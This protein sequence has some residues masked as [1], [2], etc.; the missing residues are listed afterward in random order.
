MKHDAL[1]SSC[2]PL[3]IL[4]LSITPSSLFAQEIPTKEVQIAGALSP[5]P[6]NLKEGS[7]SARF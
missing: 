4:T 1:F 6:G 7:S 2:L 3:I 5:A